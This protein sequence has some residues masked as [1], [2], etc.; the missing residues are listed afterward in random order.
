MTKNQLDLF[1]FRGVVLLQTLPQPL[2]AL[3]KR[4]VPRALA[5]FIGIPRGNLC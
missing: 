5:I 2:S 1:G 4:V 3:G